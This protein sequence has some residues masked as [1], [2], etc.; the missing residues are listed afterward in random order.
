M[1]K[2]LVDISDYEVNGAPLSLRWGLYVGDQIYPD[3]KTSLLPAFPQLLLAETL[4]ARDRQFG[5]RIRASPLRLRPND[6]YEKTYNE[7]K[8]YLIMTEAA[9]SR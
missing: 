8:A 5:S 3:A 2:E 1:R 6:A 4:K 9:G 7:L